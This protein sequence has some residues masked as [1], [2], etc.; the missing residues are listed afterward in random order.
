M[1]KKICQL[2]SSQRN[3]TCLGFVGGVAFC[4]LSCFGELEVSL[5]F[6]PK[7]NLR[8]TLESGFTLLS[9]LFSFLFSNFC[10]SCLVSA[11][12]FISW[13]FFCC[14]D[15]CFRDS[16]CFV[17]FFCFF[18]IKH[19]HVKLNVCSFKF[20][21]LRFINQ[22]WNANISFCWILGFQIKLS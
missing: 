6:L 17:C 18:V 20:C 15:A 5:L 1:K 7:L 10:F 12:L 14:S 2:L 19:K 9:L 21:Y 8:Q 16:F 22:L 11:A 4:G 3:E 13:S